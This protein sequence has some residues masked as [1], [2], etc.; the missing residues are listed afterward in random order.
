MLILNGT[1]KEHYSEYF[2]VYLPRKLRKSAG[3]PQKG[4]L[5]NGVAIFK[6]RFL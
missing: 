6:P 2:S 3:I 1:N 5:L 4:S